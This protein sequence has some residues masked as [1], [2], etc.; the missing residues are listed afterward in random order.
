[1][2]FNHRRKNNGFTLIEMLV[3]MAIIMILSFAIY[4]NQRSGQAPYLLKQG[5][6]KLTTDLRRAQNMAMSGTRIAGNYYGYGIFLQ[7][8]STS[9]I[10]YGEKADTGADSTIYNPSGV[11]Q[12]TIIETINF[13][14]SVVIYSPLFLSNEAHIL[15]KPPAPA[16]SI[17]DG[18]DSTL[19]TVS[20]ILN[21]PGALATKTVRVTQAGLI[22]AQ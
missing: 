1:M 21:A 5:A 19:T 6:Q 18:T 20:I 16:T 22:E 11:N 4:T 17:S 13:P 14:R 3:V 12:D 15:F 2:D 10:L 7:A 8:S 9:Y